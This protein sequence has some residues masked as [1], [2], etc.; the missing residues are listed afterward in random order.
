MSCTGCGCGFAYDRG[1]GSLTAVEVF[2]TASG[3]KVEPASNPIAAR[4]FPPWVL[5]AGP[6]AWSFL[7]T[8]G[9]VALRDVLPQSFAKRHP[10]RIKGR[11]V[12]YSK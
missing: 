2:Y 9:G 10:S 7:S 11:D 4:D 1:S 8:L 3:E 12:E 6:D 5:C